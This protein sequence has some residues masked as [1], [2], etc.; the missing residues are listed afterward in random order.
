MINSASVINVPFL[1]MR[2]QLDELAAGGTKFFHIDLMDGH[3]VPNLCM[4]IKL[5]R[6]LKDAYPQIVMD[7]H[8]MVTNPQDYIERLREA[9]ADYV[10]FHTDST[11]FVRRIINEIHGAGMKAGIVINPSQRIDHI[12][13]YIE[14]VDMVMLMAVEPGFAG[15]PLLEGSMERLQEIADLRRQYGCKF[16][17]SVDGGIDHE[18]CLRCREIGV[19]MIVG[20]VHNIF[21]Q[22]DGLKSAC[23]R[24]EREFGETAG[25]E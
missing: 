14:Y 22:P 12:E 24:F 9:G 11:P 16:L 6:E 23:M 7:V 4:P 8:I 19:D 10:A 15:Q 3:Y 1:E 5:I 18:R 17:I 2:E 20:T 21:K 13:P 25:G